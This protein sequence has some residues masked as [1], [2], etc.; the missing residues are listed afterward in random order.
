M[1]CESF[2]LTT[3]ECLRLIYLYIHLR[4]DWSRSEIRLLELLSPDDNSTS[5]VKSDTQGKLCCASFEED[6]EYTAVSY[7][8]G[9]PN[10]TV[11]IT[12]VLPM[13]SKM[14]MI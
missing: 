11:P 10:Q 2:N 1:G 3:I 7:V 14:Y 9:D 5:V 4:L 8:W 13:N 6:I 12:I